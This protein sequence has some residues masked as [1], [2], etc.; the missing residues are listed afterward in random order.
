MHASDATDGSDANRGAVVGRLQLE[1]KC[2]DME[3]E[4]AEMGDELQTLAA[5]KADAQHQLDAYVQGKEGLYDALQEIAALNS[6]ITALD[7]DVVAKTAEVRTPCNA[8]VERVTPR[9]TCNA[10]RDT[11][12]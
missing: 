2:A 11:R 6:R 3:R 5:A 9:P 12:G 4:L 8:V 1:Q 10:G 7:R